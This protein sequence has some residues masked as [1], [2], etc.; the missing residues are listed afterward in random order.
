MDNYECDLDGDGNFGTD[1][2]R[3][4]TATVRFDAGGPHTVSVVWSGDRD[5]TASYNQNVRQIGSVAAACRRPAAPTAAG[6]R[7][8]PGFPPPDRSA[9]RSTTA[10]PSPNDP[11]VTIDAVWPRG[12]RSVTISN[13][14]A[15]KH[16]QRFP[17][18]AHLDW[19]LAATG[20]ER[21]PK[22]VDVGFDSTGSQTD[23]II[24]DQTKPTVS[25][26]AVVDAGAT[27]GSATVAQAADARTQTYRVRI[28]AK[29]APSGV[30]KVSSRRTSSTR[31]R[32]AVRSDRP[33]QGS[34]AP[35]YLR[36][37]DRA[38]NFSRCR[39]CSRRGQRRRVPTAT[40]AT[41]ITGVRATMRRAAGT[42]SCASATRQATP[43]PASTSA[44]VAR[45][46][47]TTAT[48]SRTPLPPA[49]PDRAGAP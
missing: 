48:R 11:C 22:T 25:A 46:A 41:T 32:C 34:H 42:A 45:G 30:T 24:L 14:G 10:A 39:R 49:H 17:V 7:P 37:Q 5:D 4:P 8:P 38:G 3:D 21:L 26:A 29:D 19:T 2:G 18:D 16:P 12:A 35:K 13:D 9:R 33:L 20:P 1:T 43:G 44:S 27:A 36:V 47:S 15:F 31:A 23:A 40:P 28:R 6:A